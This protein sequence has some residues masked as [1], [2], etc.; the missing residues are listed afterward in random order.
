MDP[1]MILAYGFS[2]F[3]VVMVWLIAILAIIRHIRKNK[4]MKELEIDHISLYF[5]DYFPT[6]IKNFDLVTKSKFDTWSASIGKRLKVVGGSISTV[7]AFRKG[8]DPRLKSLEK[9]VDALEKL[10]T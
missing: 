9:Q 5:D 2:I 3:F 1:L 4:A 7:Q 8:F 10:S 6:I